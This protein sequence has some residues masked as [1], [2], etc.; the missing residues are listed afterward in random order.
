MM[1][2]ITIA[3]ML[4]SLG[5]LAYAQDDETD[6]REKIQLGIKVGVSHSNVYDSQ[7]EEFDSDPKFGLT[8]GAFVM[9]PVGK[10]LGVQPEV[11]ITQK[12][13]QGNGS[14]L[15][16]KYDFKRTTTFLEIP[17]LFAFKPSEFIT[18]LAGPQYSYLLLQK[19]EFTSSFVSYSQ[20]QE[21][22]QDN[23]RKNIFGLVGGVDIN[24][25]HIVIGARA[26]WDMQN[27]K[28][29]GTSNT[30]RYKNICTQLTIGYKL[31]KS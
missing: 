2:R 11:M 3:A 12:G 25:Q 1:Y 16:N 27:N 24:L 6:N 14:L 19:D 29:D 4:L 20:E 26:G 18:V 30:P 9:F 7:G 8:A 22:K 15:G 28:A 23:I 31:Y 13:F 21:F 10:Y 5:S 17:I